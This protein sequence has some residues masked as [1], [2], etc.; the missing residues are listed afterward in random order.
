MFIFTKKFYNTIS[1]SRLR[2]SFERVDIILLRQIPI[3]DEEL[4]N[5]K[6]EVL[7]ET[8]VAYPLYV[9]FEDLNELTKDPYSENSERIYLKYRDS[10]YIKFIKEYDDIMR[11][12]VN[13]IYTVQDMTLRLNR[14]GM[15]Q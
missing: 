1:L 2:T 9:M 11:V 7:N 13:A 10:K 8:P 14:M 6:L 12:R 5:L 15:V 4:H 3:T